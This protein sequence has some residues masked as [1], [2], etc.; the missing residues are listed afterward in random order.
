MSKG[1]NKIIDLLNRAGIKFQRE[2]SFSDL[3]HGL[4]RY[5]F[6][7]P[8]LNIAIEF[9][10]PQ[11]KTKASGCWNQTEEEY[12]QAIKR[13]KEKN[14]YCLKNNIPLY[15][16]PYEYRDKLTLELLTDEKF[17]VKE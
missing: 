4:F 14:E 1:E 10:G 13:D 11:H 16:I 3:R 8:D 9:D 5:D 15:R 12:K 17:L 2:K 7:L 6:Y